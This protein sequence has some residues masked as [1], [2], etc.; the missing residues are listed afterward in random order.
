MLCYGEAHS[1]APPQPTATYHSDAMNLDFDYPSSF[2]SQGADDSG[3]SAGAG[4]SCVSTPVAAMD[5]RTG[6]NMIFLR[7]FDG[8]CIGKQI[9]AD[10]GSAAATS[11]ND[12]LGQL[13]K[14]DLSKGTD[15]E[16]SGHSA[17]SV[18]GAVKLKGVKPAGT[19]VY[20][21]GSCAAVG[22]DLVCFVFLSSDCRTLA[23]I[24]TSTV[25]FADAAAA[26]IIPSN[27]ALGCKP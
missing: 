5:M 15:Y 11:L 24:S 23:A 14:P 18:S 17:S 13:G 7:R 1:Q 6:F 21:V 27:V 8:A 20:G 22:K 9:A 2:A 3:K 10:R 16:I 4:K 26:P 25:K 19:V 12:T